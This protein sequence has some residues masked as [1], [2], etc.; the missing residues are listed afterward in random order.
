MARTPHDRSF[1]TLLELNGQKM[2]IDE[3]AR[4][5]VEFRVTQVPPSP[6]RPH[7][8]DYALTLYDREQGERLVGFDDAHAVASARGQGRKKRREHDHTHRLRTIQPYEYQDAATLVG[9]FWQAVDS[10]LAVCR[11]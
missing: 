4:Y 8:L 7:G 9:D 11:I 2:A 10:V 5:W 3:E 1:D 6:T